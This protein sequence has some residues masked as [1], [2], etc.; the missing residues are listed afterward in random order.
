MVL[1]GPG[2]S[3]PGIDFE[4]AGPRKRI[5][6]VSRMLKKSVQDSIPSL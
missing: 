5:F 1:P 6:F 4:R 3:E 2:Q